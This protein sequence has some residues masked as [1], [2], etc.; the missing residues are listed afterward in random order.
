IWRV[1]ADEL[2]DDL[3]GEGMTLSDLKVQ[4]RGTESGPQFEANPFILSNNEITV[5]RRNGTT[6]T[7]RIPAGEYRFTVTGHSKHAIGGGDTTTFV[8][9]V[10]DNVAPHLLRRS[11]TVNEGAVPLDL[12][13]IVSDTEDDDVIFNMSALG[14]LNFDKDGIY[15]KIFAQADESRLFEHWMKGFDFSSEG[16]YQIA[17]S[18]YDYYNLTPQNFNFDLTVNDADQPVYFKGGFLDWHLRPN[19]PLSQQSGFDVNVIKDKVTEGDV[20]DTV[21]YSLIFKEDLSKI[22]LGGYY[23]NLGN[24]VYTDS[25][26]THEEIQNKIRRGEIKNVANRL[27]VTLDPSTGVLSGAIRDVYAGSVEE[28]YVLAHS[29]GEMRPVVAPIKIQISGARHFAIQKG[30]SYSIPI[31]S[32]MHGFEQLKSVLVQGSSKVSLNHD[33]TKVIINTNSS[34][35]VAQ[36]FTLKFKDGGPI[37]DHI[38]GQQT[39]DSIGGAHADVGTLWHETESTRSFTFKI[40][41][42]VL[43]P[44][45]QEQTKRI[46]FKDTDNWQFQK[47]DLDT[48]F[49]DVDNDPLIYSIVSKPSWVVWNNS[50]QTLSTVDGTNPDGYH[51]VKVKALEPNSGEYAFVTLGLVVEDTNNAPVLNHD[52]GP[53][54]YVEGENISLDFKSYFREIDGQALSFQVY[55]FDPVTDAPMMPQGLSVSN[56]VLS[57][58]L[59]FNSEGR[60]GLSVTASDGEAQTTHITQFNV[61]HANQS[62][63]N[64][65][66]KEGQNTETLFTRG[67]TGLVNINR[68]ELINAPSFVSVLS[69][70]RGLSFKPDYSDA[71]TYSFSV[72]LYP[73]EVQQ[74]HGVSATDSF[75]ID[76]RTVDYKI[77]ISNT[78][79]APTARKISTTIGVQNNQSWS[80]S[81]AQ[82]NALFNDLDGDTLAYTIVSK[83]SWVSWSSSSQSLSVGSQL[84]PVGNHTIRIK[85]QDSSGASAYTNIVLSVSDS[86]RAPTS[87]PFTILDQTAGRA[88]S[89]ISFSRFFSD[90]D[91]DALTY[92]ISFIRNDGTD[93]SISMPS[94]LRF[95]SNGVL[96]GTPRFAGNYILT[97]TA[98]DGQKS[99]SR[100]A[101][102]VVHSGSG[103]GIG[104]GDDLML[105]ASTFNMQSEPTPARSSRALDVPTTLSKEKG[106]SELEVVPEPIQPSIA[107]LVDVTPSV[108]K[109]QPITESAVMFAPVQAR[110][111]AASVSV[112]PPVTPGLS[113]AM[114][115]YWFTYDANNRVVMDGAQLVGGQVSISS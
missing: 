45:V 26:T 10:E 66:G 29:S 49:G 17:G 23:D 15:S 98:S 67:I 94:G 8:V 12:N 105:M 84:K 96:S 106:T 46:N 74:I 6:K 2:F 83:P 48:I 88:M 108:M 109:S 64:L 110:F 68:T 20:E 72:K 57:G 89:P 51:E 33:K 92:R 36:S 59:G 24:P 77:V 37:E 22:S 82:I 113:S 16:V 81:K 65:Q 61:G 30:S 99:T 35:A 79:R 28:I 3:A 76:T 55:T 102:L 7:V 101:R 11:Y 93:A 43:G 60:Y 38:H 115:Q 1:T 90:P 58:T 100:S 62:V 104:G 114:E 32:D 14:G 53:F 39:S 112:T 4:Y 54:N 111:S 44:T 47:S 71:G 107:P 103:I 85:A 25:Y 31:T 42:I 70:N 86:N 97:V 91:G 40:S 5:K 63:V 69:G 80:H 50:T 18:Y 13:D 95:S 9:N 56:G 75:T 21:S 52:F 78:N 19:T 27:G 41:D 87:S 34:D 73:G